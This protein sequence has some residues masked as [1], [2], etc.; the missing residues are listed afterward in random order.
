MRDVHALPYGRATAP[1]AS[2]TTLGHYCLFSRRTRPPFSGMLD[3]SGI[4][5]NAKRSATSNP[6]RIWPPFAVLL[7]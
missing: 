6:S 7:K 2:N 3:N 4:Y 1:I 5:T